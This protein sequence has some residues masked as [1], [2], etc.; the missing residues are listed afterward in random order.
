M[1]ALQDPT[2]AVAIPPTCLPDWGVADLPEPQPP[3]WRQ[4]TRFIG[5]G[6][7]MMGVQIGGGEWLSR[8]RRSPRNTA[9][10]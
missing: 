4:W 7:V 5:P 3:S 9:A 10:A 1:S 6:I 2:P 8:P